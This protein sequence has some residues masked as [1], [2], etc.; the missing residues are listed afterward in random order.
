MLRPG[1]FLGL[2]VLA[3]IA[4]AHHSSV[5]IFDTNQT[6]EVT[7][8]VTS[9]SWRNPHGQ[10]V[11]EVEGESGNSVEWEAEM[12]GVSV[13]RNRGYGQ[14]FIAVGDV[15]TIAGLPARR[16]VQEML[17]K[18]ILLPSGYE[19]DF[20]SGRPYF[21]A[22]KNGNLIG[23]ITEDANVEQATV[24]AEG[25]FRVWSTIMDDPASF[26]MFK[27]GYPLTEAAKAFLAQWDP[28]DND[29]LHCGTKYMPLIMITPFPIDFIR[30]GDNI[31]M[32]IEEFDARRLIHMADDA[33][34]PDEHTQFGFSR[35]HWEGDTLVV[36]TD[37]IAAGYFS[38]DGVPQSDR[39]SVVERFIPSENYNRLDYRITITDPVYLAESFDLTRYFVWLPA[40]SVHPYECL[41]RY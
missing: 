29:L 33:V 1:S 26:P 16:P 32:R 14:D 18:N 3:G 22:G 21:P 39:I 35:G 40:N 28:L 13:M 31:L 8:T 34:A 38:M 37:H 15:I 27:G 36:E 7:G 25:L 41:D 12:A 10:I 4:H 24:S 17:A 2:A 30:D 20:G 5:A 11:L 19:F 6:I 9:V 23:R